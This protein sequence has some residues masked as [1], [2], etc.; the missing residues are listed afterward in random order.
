MRKYNLFEVVFFLHIQRIMLDAN[1]LSSIAMFNS[2]KLKQML[3]DIFIKGDKD[4][5]DV[6][7]EKPEILTATEFLWFFKE[8]K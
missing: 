6:N 4:F 2:E 1:I 5:D 7:I 3:M 8:F